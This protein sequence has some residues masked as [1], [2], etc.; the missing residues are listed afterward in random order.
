M[1]ATD[2]DDYI[3]RAHGLVCSCIGHISTMLLIGRLLLQ[4]EV[5]KSA[6]TH[7][8]HAAIE[9]VQPRFMTNCFMSVPGVANPKIAYVRPCWMVFGLC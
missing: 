7:M 5:F 1:V 6:D 8:G 2:A 9:V 4:L 3:K